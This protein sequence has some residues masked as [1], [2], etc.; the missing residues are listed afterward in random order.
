MGLWKINLILLYTTTTTTTTIG[1]LAGYD[2]ETLTFLDLLTI[3]TNPR[4]KIAV[5]RIV[6]V[7]FFVKN[8]I[9]AMMIETIKRTPY[10]TLLLWIPRILIT[11]VLGLKP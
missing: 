11:F 4:T 9:K 7:E 10:T 6:P 8:G 2:T 3:N 1:L 5:T